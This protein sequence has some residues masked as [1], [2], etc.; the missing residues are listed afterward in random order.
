MAVKGAKYFLAT[1]LKIEFGALKPEKGQ[2]EDEL[3]RKEYFKDLLLV[4]KD[5]ILKLDGVK[6]AGYSL[7]MPTSVG[8]LLSGSSRAFGNSGSSYFDYGCFE[9][10]Y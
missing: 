6:I 10:K 9:F 5:I 4:M 8:Y 3:A 1:Y 2:D 7:S